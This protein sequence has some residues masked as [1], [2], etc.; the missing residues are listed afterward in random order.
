MK[1]LFITMALLLCVAV[2]PSTALATWTVSVAEVAQAEHYFK[3]SVTL[4]SD[5]SAMSATDLVAEMP[6]NVKNKVQ[7]ETLMAMK[8]SP[9]SSTVAPDTTINI[10]LSDDE[11]DALYTTTGNSYTA[12]S[13]HDLSDD[14]SIFLPIFGTF[15]V[16]VNDIGTAGDQVTL[17][18]ITW[19][20]ED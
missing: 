15:N 18:F 14:I 6:R 2:M 11:G 13:W 10:T 7:G 8:I 12:I 3:W 20:E 1:R 19:M 16:A 5:G 4:T 17:Y 9:G